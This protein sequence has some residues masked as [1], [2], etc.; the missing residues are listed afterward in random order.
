MEVSFDSILGWTALVGALTGIP[1]AIDL[2]SRKTAERRPV[3]IKVAHAMIGSGPDLNQY[4][5][6]VQITVVNRSDEDIYIENV[7]FRFRDGTI[8]SYSGSG[9]AAK[10]GPS[11]PH[12]LVP[13][14]NSAFRFAVPGLAA[15]IERAGQLPR[16]AFIK[17]ATDRTH[18]ERLDARRF[19]SW[20]TPPSARS[21]STK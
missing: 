20:I 8:L 19:H 12:R 14:T 16:S 10:S 15:A 4:S 17:D 13:K 6:W 5:R 3:R 9:Y 11:L 2:L 21:A 18:Q 7:G 1:S